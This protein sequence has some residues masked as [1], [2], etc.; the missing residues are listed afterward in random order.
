MSEQEKPEKKKYEKKKFVFKTEDEILN[1]GLHEGKSIGEIMRKEPS[2]IDWCVKN[3][4]GFK[5][6]KK[7][8]VRFE[9]IKQEK[10]DNEKI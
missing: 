6:W 2:Y 9:E 8:S 10:L 7:L 3:F 4:K 1:F 5:M